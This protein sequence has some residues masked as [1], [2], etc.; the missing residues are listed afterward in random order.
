MPRATRISAKALII[1]DDHLLAVKLDDDG[2]VYYILPG[3]G[4]DAEETLPEAVVREVAEEVGVE[5]TPGPLVLAI[6]GVHGEPAHRIDL[7]FA[8]AYIGPAS[9][10]A[11]SP[12]TNQVAAE[13][14]PIADL[15]DLPL[16]PSRLRRAIMR[17]HRGEAQPVYLGNEGIGDP[18]WRE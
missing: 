10:V 17:L 7:V 9:D 15:L 18:E 8:C 16:Y 1:R 14:L 2:D 12:D 4:L 6:E 11:A 3:G 5:V 13:W